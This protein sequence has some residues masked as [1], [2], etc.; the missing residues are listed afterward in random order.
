M[1]SSSITPFGKGSDEDTLSNKSISGR[2][3]VDNTL[4]GV[5]YS[6]LVVLEKETAK[7]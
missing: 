6:T 7:K 4:Y 5:G 2:G 1:F 3:K